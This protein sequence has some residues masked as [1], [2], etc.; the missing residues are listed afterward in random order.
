[1][2]QRVRVRTRV[3]VGVHVGFEKTILTHVMFS[4]TSNCVADSVSAP[5]L[6]S[7]Y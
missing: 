2:C 3:C 5:L 6:S 1:M 4:F 7:E